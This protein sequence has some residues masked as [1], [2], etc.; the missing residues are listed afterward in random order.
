[1]PRFYFDI[2]V[3]DEKS[4]DLNGIEL[5]SAEDAHK[6]ALEDVDILGRYRGDGTGTTYCVL[7]VLDE[8]RNLLFGFRFS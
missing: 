2:L 7:E 1:M 6:L 3:N 8:R 5:A 4:A